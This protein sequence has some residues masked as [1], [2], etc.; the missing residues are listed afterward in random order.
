MVPVTSVQ[1]HRVG[2][3]LV[4]GA[5][6]FVSLERRSEATWPVTL[7]SQSLAIQ[8]GPGRPHRAAA[9]GA[10]LLMP[11]FPHLTGVLLGAECISPL[12]MCEGMLCPATACRSRGLGLQTPFSVQPRGRA[13]GHQ[14]KAGRAVVGGQGQHPPQQPSVPQP[15]NS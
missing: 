4:L 6:D 15:S 12:A 13:P 1:P 7:S 10:W 5:E 11:L 3:L 2:P 8:A 14:R 9:K